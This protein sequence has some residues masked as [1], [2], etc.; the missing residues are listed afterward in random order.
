MVSVKLNGNFAS[1]MQFV[2]LLRRAER[3]ISIERVILENGN[4]DLD[5]L[6]SVFIVAGVKLAGI[7]AK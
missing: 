4:K 3:F 7:P 5:N 2:N 1:I 6:N